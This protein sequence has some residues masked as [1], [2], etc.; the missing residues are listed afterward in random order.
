[1][2]QDIQ[3][4]AGL[5]PAGKFN[6][7][8][9]AWEHDQPSNTAI[10][11]TTLTVATFNIWFADFHFEARMHAIIALLK[12]SNADVIALQEVTDVSHDLLLQSPWI[13][14]HFYVSD[15]NGATFYPYG[16]M[17]LSRLP[18]KRLHLHPLTSDMNR[19]ALV[20]AFEI[21]GQSLSI[22]TNSAHAALMGDF[23]FCSSWAENA[24]IN[25]QYIDA[26]S[27]LHPD[28]AGYTEDTSINIMRQSLDREERKVRFDRV[29]MR[30]DNGCWQA[31]HMQRI[32][33][34]PISPQLPDVFPSDHFGLV[35]RFAWLPKE[36]SK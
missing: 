6:Q 33:M 11:T 10:N 25:A 29:I 5:I 21:N 14:A 26:W 30:S 15:I 4:Q 32:G 17:L 22:A 8:A 16:V 18:I 3:T 2:H 34:A 1:M 12:S 27:A 20:A 7:E 24:N 36:S 28:A 19:K 35:T 23:N 31:N 9:A 13:R